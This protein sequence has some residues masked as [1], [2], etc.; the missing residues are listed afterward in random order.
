[1]HVGS[2]ILCYVTEEFSMLPSL[3]LTPVI[4]FSSH[5]HSVA[6]FIL[7][8]YMQGS[9][10]DCVSSWFLLG[11]PGKALNAREGRGGGEV[12]LRI[13]ASDLPL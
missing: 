1:M 13:L 4:L 8:S 10:L 11:S 7:L 3:G 6:L 12:S 5:S 2:F 9:W